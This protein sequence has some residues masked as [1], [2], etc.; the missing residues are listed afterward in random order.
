MNSAETLGY[1]MRCYRREKGL[2][3]KELTDIAGVADGAICKY[4]T[5]QIMPRENTIQ[6]IAQA[7]DIDPAKLY[8]PIGKIDIM[9]KVVALC[10]SELANIEKCLA[11]NYPKPES[12][13]AYCIGQ[14]DALSWCISV[15][16]GEREANK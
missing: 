3:Q 1:N 8:K 6:R 12:I 9:E 2:T 4:E 5:G 16:N 11:S 14:K 10:E 15:I 13:Q 7:L